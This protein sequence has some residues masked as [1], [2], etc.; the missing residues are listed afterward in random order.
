[1]SLDKQHPFDLNW[2]TA[3]DYRDKR[4][5]FKDMDWIRGKARLVTYALGEVDE[6]IEELDV[7]GK[8]N[9]DKVADE[10]NDVFN[11]LVPI[12]SQ[13]YGREFTPSDH[14]YNV[15]GAGKHSD[16]FDRLKET[17]RNS[18]DDD[19]ALIEALRLL[20]SIA[21]HVLDRDS[22]VLVL[23]IIK[24]YKKVS[25]NY[26]VELYNGKDPL[27]GADLAEKDKELVFDHV[28]RAL[29]VIRAQV[30]RPLLPSDVKNNQEH[31]RNW[32]NSEDALSKLSQGITV[33]SKSLTSTSTESGLYVP[34]EET[35]VFIT[36]SSGVLFENNKDNKSYV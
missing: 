34:S 17:I 29:K 32:Q 28:T 16:V 4:S 25:A 19:K 3:N 10:L 2:Q 1:M 23:Q 15:N 36:Q 33:D 26:P 22:S 30:K 21:M 20:W 31:I 18:E 12:I 35:T 11:M 7:I 24:T 9:K 8:P 5:L 6:T 27:T 13:T 14:L